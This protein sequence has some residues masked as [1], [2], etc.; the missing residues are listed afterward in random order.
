M[1]K[2]VQETRSY[3]SMFMNVRLGLLYHDELL[4]KEGLPLDGASSIRVRAKRP[5]KQRPFGSSRIED[6]LVSL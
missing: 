4:L 1:G 6:L 2:N 5:I 3:R